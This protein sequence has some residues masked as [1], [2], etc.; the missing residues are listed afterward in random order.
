MKRLLSAIVASVAILGAVSSY[1][2][3]LPSR[4]NVVQMVESGAADTQVS[5]THS[6]AGVWLQQALSPGSQ[7]ISTIAW[8]SVGGL[9]ALTLV[10][11][12]KSI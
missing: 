3:S 11:R 8:V 12:R 2:L 6:S 1:A 5:A 9:I 10:A 7:G 4:N